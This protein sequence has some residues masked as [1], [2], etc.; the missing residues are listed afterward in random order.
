MW[1]IKKRSEAKRTCLECLSP[2][3]SHGEAWVHVPVWPGWGWGGFVCCI[4]PICVPSGGGARAAPW[5]DGGSNCQTQ[6]PPSPGSPD[7]G[8]AFVPAKDTHPWQGGQGRRGD[9]EASGTIPTI[10]KKGGLQRKRGEGAQTDHVIQLE[11]GPGSSLLPNKGPGGTRGAQ[12]NLPPGRWARGCVRN[13]GCCLLPHGTGNPD[14][15]VHPKSFIRERETHRYFQTTRCSLFLLHPLHQSPAR[16]MLP[17][18]LPLP[19]LLAPAK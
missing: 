10:T 2:P 17:S 15:N 7:L 3:P 8:Q 9:G 11:E 13:V 6:A 12:R 18:E 16:R 4:K 5:G 14:R 19:S 1:E